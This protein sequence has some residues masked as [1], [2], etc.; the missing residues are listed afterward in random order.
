MA[1]PTAT[2]G[3]EAVES[4]QASGYAADIEA[5]RARATQARLRLDELAFETDLASENYLEALHLLETTTEEIE[6]A[7]AGLEE[8]QQ[9][10][11]Y[12]GGLLSERAIGTYQGSDL[13]FVQFLFASTGFDNLVARF[14]ML[15]TIMDNDAS[16]IRE[17]RQIRSEIEQ[18]RIR[19]VEKREVERETAE[20]AEAEYENVQTSLAEQQRLLASLD[21]EVRRLVEEERAA[22]EAEQLRIAQARQAEEVAARAAAEAEQAATDESTSTETAGTEDSANSDSANAGGSGN[23]ANAGGG[24]NSGNNSANNNGN[25]GNGNSNN[26]GSGSGNT[27]GGNNN[28]SSGGSG[29]AANPP[30]NPPTNTNPTPPPTGTLGRERPGVVQVAR[31]FVGV[32]PYLWGGTTPAGFDCSGLVMFAYRE[33]YGINLPRTSRQQFHAGTFIPAN[34]SNQMRPGDLVFFSRTGRPEN[35]HHVGIY[36]GNNRMIHAPSSGRTV[37]EQVIWRSDFIGGVRVR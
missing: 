24:N 7:E 9:R 26:S 17:T 22:I 25:A 4:V 36:V 35:I 20:R 31:R 30:A 14:N 2:E 29:S 15:R 21:G 34:R 10:L 8:S 6:E 11:D 32:T 12:V 37:S 18:T 23:A 28:S 33:A 5:A 3:D 16:M 1:T 13:S 27:S 19:L